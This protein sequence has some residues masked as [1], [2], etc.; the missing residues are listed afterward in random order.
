MRPT[1]P[2]L[3][4]YEAFDALLSNAA[5]PV[6][7]FDAH[8]LITLWNRGAERV[9]GWSAAETIGRPIPGVPAQRTEDSER[10]F[11]RVL[12]GERF[13]GIDV[14][15]RRRDGSR[16]R[17][18]ISIVPLS[19]AA[20]EVHGMLAVGSEQA[21]APGPTP[22]TDDPEAIN[23]LSRRIRELETQLR[24]LQSR[25][26]GDAL[27]PHFLL[28]SLHAISVLVRKNAPDEAIQ[29][30]AQLGGLL[31]TVL[32]REEADE[33]TLREEIEFLQRYIEVHR[34]RFGDGLKVEVEIES[35]AME[36]LV[37][38]LI[39][40]PLVENSLRH[41]LRPESCVCEIGIRARRVA[42][43]LHIEVR[44]NGRGLRSTPG[45]GPIEG[46]G[47][48]TLRS[49]LAQI[50]GGRARFELIDLHGG[51]VLVPLVI[52]FRTSRP[53]AIGRAAG[54]RAASGHAASNR[55]ANGPADAPVTDEGG[56]AA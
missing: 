51:G 6:V 28:N 21:G 33:I 29:V 53:A 56:E 3:E 40:Q 19:N 5:A 54:R 31:R 10:I 52:P 35:S 4:Y 14:D 37:P 42:N 27:P 7:A 46:I 1:L 45:N 25:W 9:F 34:F 11:Q 44:D 16:V 12:A 32:Y 43:D 47:L 15:M 26:V 20:G 24:E 17:L 18:T 30:L 36:A 23:V 41:G 39:L 49:R 22:V 55:A 8:G 13:D 38:N 48:R 2:E 50:Y